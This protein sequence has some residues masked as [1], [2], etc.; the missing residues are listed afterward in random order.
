MKLAP[1]YDFFTKAEIISKIKYLPS[2]TKVQIEEYLEKITR[3]NGRLKN[4]KKTYKLAISTL[5]SIDINPIPLKSSL[6]IRSLPSLLPYFNE[7][8]IQ[9][10]KKTRSLIKFKG[11]LL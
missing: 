2:K 3:K 9:P 6:G 10:Q 1:P 11:G 7:S 4:L 8:E 5:E